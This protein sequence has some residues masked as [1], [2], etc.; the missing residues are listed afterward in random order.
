VSG[1]G[2][3]TWGVISTT[4]QSLEIQM[5]SR[6]KRMPNIQKFDALPFPN[7][8]SIPVLGG[9]LSRSDNPFPL[10]EAVTASSAPNETS[11]KYT[12]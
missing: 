1:S 5:K 11:P 4:V 3:G 2:A 9:R 7:M 12:T 8:K 10:S 6:G